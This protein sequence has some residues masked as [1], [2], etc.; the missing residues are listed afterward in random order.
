VRRCWDIVEN[1][2]DAAYVHEH[3]NDN[4]GQSYLDGFTGVQDQLEVA[5]SALEEMSARV[6]HSFRPKFD[7]SVLEVV[8]GQGVTMTRPVLTTMFRR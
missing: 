8:S 4:V 2:A 6:F 7:S 3:V 5:T 1:L